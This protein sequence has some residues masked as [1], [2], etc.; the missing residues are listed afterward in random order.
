M[1]PTLVALRSLGGEGATWRINKTVIDQLNIT[2]E[3]LAVRVSKRNQSVVEIRLGWA[4]TAL[5]NRGEIHS[6][7]WGYWMLGPSVEQDAAPTD[8]PSAAEAAVLRNPVGGSSM[9][10]ES[11][12]QDGNGWL[13]GA[14]ADY[15]VGIM[16]HQELTGGARVLT[17]R[18]VPNSQTMID[19]IVV[20]PSGVWVVDSRNWSGRIKYLFDRE[21]ESMRLWVGKHDQTP[22]VELL[23]AVVIPVAQAVGD[24]EVNVNPVMAVIDGNWGS[25][26]RRTKPVTHK[27]V[28]VTSADD[29][30][31]R[32]NRPGSLEP[33]RIDDLVVRL[34]EVFEPN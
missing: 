34:D 20:A 33:E 16:L 30:V 27:G 6:P 12:S 26:F 5:K 9:F 18:R 31:S 29:V 23:Y 2:E 14:T 7:R 8:D 19:H 11:L 22:K 21:S 3:Q 28:L 13:K 10:R 1:E 25:G 4:R 32:I 24:I 15:L 17:D